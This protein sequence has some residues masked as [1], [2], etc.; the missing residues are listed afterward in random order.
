MAVA[1]MNQYGLLL[2]SLGVGA[3]V[4]DPAVLMSTKGPVIFLPYNFLRAA[5]P[6][7]HSWSVTSDSIAAYLASV[8]RIRSLVLIKALDP[9]ESPYSLTAAIEAK[10]IDPCFGCYLAKD[11]ECWIVN[12][13]HPRRLLQLQSL[14]TRL[15]ADANAKLIEH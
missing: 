15:I 3:A 10:I 8:L 2:E 1:A 4:D 5:D 9:P 12:G 13:N 14:G 7:P 11:A 6:L